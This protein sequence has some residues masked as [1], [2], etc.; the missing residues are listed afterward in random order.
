MGNNRAAI[1][2]RYSAGSGQTDQ[3]IEG[4]VRECE[5]FIKGRGL[6]LVAT[7]ADRHITGRTDRRPEFQR[8]IADAESG[9]FD[10]VVV[11][12]TDRFSRD[13]YDSAIYKRKLKNCGVQ[14]LYAAE[15]IPK[16]PEGV[17][18]EALM[19]GWAQY[20]SEELSRKVSRGMRESALKCKSAGSRPPAGYRVGPDRTY[21]LDPDAAPHI[22]HAFDMFLAGSNFTEIAR[23]LSTHG[24][25]TRRGNP[26]SSSKIRQM[27]SNRRY[28]GEYRWSDVVIEG[29]MPAIVS[30]D[31]FYMVQKKLENDRPP[32]AKSAEYYLSGKFYC[33]DCGSKYKGVS[34]TSKTGDVHYYYQCTGKCG[35]RNI[36][37]RKFEQFIADETA[38]VLLDPDMLD[39]IASK[40]CKWQDDQFALEDP[41]AD[42]RKELSSVERQLD[43]I[44]DSLALRPGSD[45]LLRKL[46]QLEAQRDALRS[47]IAIAESGRFRHSFSQDALRCGIQ[48]FLEGFPFDDEDAYAKRIIEAFVR[49]VVKTGTTVLI[50]F[51]LTG[52]DP[53]ELKDL[54]EFDRTCDLPT[55][56][57]CGR[58]L[59]CGPAA[60]LVLDYIA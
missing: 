28:I 57:I 1:Y 15:N 43:A 29:G 19:E 59:I 44:A 26:F 6:D 17:L 56:Y 40:L 41:A 35:C 5:Q 50:E 52:V 21:E 25:R 18:F 4:Q 2:A 58:T 34:G 42:I 60:V 13:K 12:S 23:Y 27:L 53:L 54:F 14:I 7:Y 31:V 22:A 37:A 51:N 30:E 55:M 32:R 38:S 39:M 36:P 20:Y 10:V 49:R 47:E 3:S 45:T 46:D 11:Y 9:S 48:V 24:V 8:M 33:G 16:G